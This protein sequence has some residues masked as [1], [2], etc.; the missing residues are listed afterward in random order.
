[1]DG[2]VICVGTS[3]PG[4]VGAI[5]RG[6][7]NFGIT[8]LRFVAP[9]CDI[10]C[11][12]ALA[13]SVHAKQSLLDATI[14]D[15]LEEAL[16]GTSLSVGT[17]AR[18]TT[19]DNRFLRKT[20]DVRDWAEGLKEFEGK[21]ALVFGREDT[22]LT[23][24]EVNQLDQLVTVPTDDYNSLNLAHAVTILSYELMRVRA[25]II[26]EPR[27]LDPDTLRHMTKAWD[28]IVDGTERRPWRREVAKGIFRK[29]VGRS[30]PSD[31]EVHNI[32]GILGSVLKRM[33]H[34]D[35]ATEG[36]RKHLAES[37]GRILRVD[38]EE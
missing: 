28:D 5:A 12:E 8:D 3:H 37:G 36:S 32:M 17:T 38:E 34:P 10:R 24:E 16:E 33:D 23:A 26:T 13:R 6:A 9:R 29:I 7:A 20:L 4:N 19:A 14:V 25:D 27:V 30:T 31:Y 18:T 11:D 22:G 21:V 15:T 35:W 2:T 1:M